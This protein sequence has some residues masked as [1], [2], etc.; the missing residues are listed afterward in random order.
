MARQVGLVKYS[1]T[2]GGVRHFKIK[3]LD[4]DFAGLAGGPTK[5]QVRNDEAFVRTRE[6]MNEFGGCAKAAKSLR[7][8][9]SQIIKQY[10]D[11]RLTGRL[12]AIMKEI[13]L[14]DV[15]NPRGERSILISSEGQ[16]LE[17]LDYNKNIT[18]S[19]VFHAPY[20]ITSTPARDSS[21]FSIPP[22][23][24][25]NLISAPAGATHFRLVNAIAVLSDWAYNV[26]NGE[27]EPTDQSLS[28]L[29][30]IQF[31]GYLDLNTPTA[32]TDITATLPGSPLMTATVKVAN[33]IGIE[34]YQ[35]VGGNYYLFASGNALKLE[36][37][38]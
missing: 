8:A 29:S 28:G 26:S 27:Y 16:I 22:F 1:G 17:G 7:V 3:G 2:M 5:E 38:F 24:P 12:T 23:N 36:T 21:T 11:P 18:F 14:K 4:A 15:V 35:Q 32:I 6:N 30:D 31:S 19:G 37:G 10:S 25:A 33:N 13:N 34:F 9:L 20:T